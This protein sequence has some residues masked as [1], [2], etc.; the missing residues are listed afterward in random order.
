MKF[1]IIFSLVILILIPT[2]LSFAENPTSK[3]SPYLSSKV[4]QCDSLKGGD[5]TN[6]LL[7]WHEKKC[8]SSNEFI[9]ALGYLSEEE[10]GKIHTGKIAGSR[11]IATTGEGYDYNHPAFK[12][13]KGSYDYSIQDRNIYE[14][15]F[16]N[17]REFKILKQHN[18]ILSGYIDDKFVS[19]YSSCYWC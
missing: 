15:T 18:G 17:G 2:T 12:N 6:N 16:D 3:I 1:I 13:N 9:S 14:F 11:N 5:W 19:S 10:I 4:N 7:R 8:I